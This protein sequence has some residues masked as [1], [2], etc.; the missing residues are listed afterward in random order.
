MCPLFL[1]NFLFE[2]WGE[3][4]E[5]EETQNLTDSHCG[6][7]NETPSLQGLKEGSIHDNG[8]MCKGTTVF[9]LTSVHMLTHSSEPFKD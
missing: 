4:D 7:C 3:D 5:L 6:V 8:V 2:V 1:T 9:H